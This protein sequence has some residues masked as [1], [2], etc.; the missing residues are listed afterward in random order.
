M[1]KSFTVKQ[2]KIKKNLEVLDLG[3]GKYLKK[4]P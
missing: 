4:K 3:G 2:E 1:Y